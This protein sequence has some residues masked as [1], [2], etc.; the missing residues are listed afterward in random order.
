MNWVELNLGEGLSEKDL[1]FKQTQ[2]EKW[3]DQN[4]N[5]NWTCDWEFGADQGYET[6]DFYLSLTFENEEDKMKFIL[7][8]C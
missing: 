2:I 7:K 5:G 6:V 1:G 4:L 8:W 3:M